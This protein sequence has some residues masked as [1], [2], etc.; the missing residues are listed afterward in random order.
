MRVLTLPLRSAHWV[1]SYTRACHNGKASELERSIQRITTRL[2]LL[3]KQMLDMQIET[4]HDKSNARIEF[5]KL[6]KLVKLLENKPQKQT[7]GHGDAG[8]V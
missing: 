5:G 1:L 3:K 8:R 2:D 4:V 7:D 6:A